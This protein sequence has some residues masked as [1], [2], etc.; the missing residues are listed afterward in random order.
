MGIT[1]SI[2]GALAVAAGAMENA[3]ILWGAAQAVFDAI[4]FKLVR[5]D[6]DFN[7]SYISEARTTIGDAAF[8]AAFEK[9]QSI[10]LKESIE[11][12]RRIKIR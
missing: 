11:L 7:E 12:A 9:G 5:V 8:D 4:G 1:L 6:H 2:F 3:A 10:P